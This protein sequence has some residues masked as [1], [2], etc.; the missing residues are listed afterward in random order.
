MLSLLVLCALAGGA[1]TPVGSVSARFVVIRAT[2]TDI[3]IIGPVLREERKVLV[4]GMEE[5][6]RL[7]WAHAPVEVCGPVDPEFFTCP[8]DGFAF[9]EAGELDLVRSRPGE[10]DE[11]L[12][13]L[14]RWPVL[15]SD[16]NDLETGPPA[17]QVRGRRPVEVM[18]PEDYN[19]DGWA[20]E[21]L[22]QVKPSGRAATTVPRPKRSTRSR[23]RKESWP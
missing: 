21:F 20:T 22:L 10:P 1:R 11:P 14:A 7:Q 12:A 3:P 5:I 16:K 23:S 4:G 8:C 18:V 17:A 6:W 9:G 13:V 19:N 2:A 15:D